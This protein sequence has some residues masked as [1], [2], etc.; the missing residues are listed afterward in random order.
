MFLLQVE[1]LNSVIVDLQ[2]KCDELKTRLEAMELGVTNGADDSLE[3]ALVLYN[4]IYHS[5][6]IYIT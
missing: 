2:H 5:N 3:T 4:I 1:F 6:Y